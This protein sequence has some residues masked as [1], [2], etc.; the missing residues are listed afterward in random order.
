[1]A[2]LQERYYDQL[3]ERIRMDRYPSQQLLDRVES[4]LWNADQLVEYVDVLLDK[5]DESWYPSSQLLD[6]VNRMLA[7]VAVVAA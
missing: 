7:R 2:S 1:M 6:R 4:T 3:I 5:I